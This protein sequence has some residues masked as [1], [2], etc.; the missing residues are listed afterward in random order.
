MF[1]PD[2]IIATDIVVVGSGVAG[3]LTALTAAKKK[4]VLV[5]SKT[6]L[7][8][9]ATVRAQGGIAAVLDQKNDRFEDH[10]ADT[11]KAGAYHNDRKIVRYVVEEAP[12]AIEKLREYG[13][14]FDRD[15]AREGGHSAARI[16]HVK[17]HTGKNIEMALIQAVRRHPNITIWEQTTAL[18]LM[19]ENATCT[20]VIV[21]KDKKII[22][23]RAAAVVLATGGVGQLFQHT[24]NPKV[25][26]GT[27]IAMAYR[28][29]A[30]LK[31]LE[32]IQFH[33]T[34]LADRANPH[35]LLS[36]ALRGAG[37][38]LI[39]SNRQRF[40][41][42][43][44]PRGELATRDLL[45]RLIYEEQTKNQKAKNSIYLDM[46]HLDPKKTKKN[47]PTIYRAIQQRLKKDLTKEPIPI[48]PAAHYLCG[49]IVVNRHGETTI[50]NLYAVGE[51][52]CTGLHGAN[53]L[54]SNSLLEAAVFA[55]AAGTRIAQSHIAPQT[56]KPPSLPYRYR[57]QHANLHA[58]TKEI[59]TIMWHNVGIIRTKNKLRQAIQAIRQL[60]AREA[61]LYP[62]SAINEQRAEARAMLTAAMLIAEAA[63]HRTISHTGKKSLGCHWVRPVKQL[64][65][66]P[67]V[68]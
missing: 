37:A 18:D 35:M 50:R 25:A 45:T 48:T 57:K 11:M 4:R 24:T 56:N 67:T 41:L 10:I 27:G 26:V 2:K 66:T 30:A 21:I 61:L 52:S 36:E 28:A 49:G 47:F 68:N 23:I 44:D 8:D 15:A 20:G 29:G 22:A 63:L 3:L 39:N 38:H 59:Q 62:A 58:L 34:A 55:L 9:G 19:V 5:M 46:T 6:K 31:D 53:R 42:T 65:V 32:F 43:H 54:A 16:T 1:R 51:I 33:P 64:G 7:D 14:R 40:T 13:V 12:R 60:R 17:D